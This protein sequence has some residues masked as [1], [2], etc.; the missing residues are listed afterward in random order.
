MKDPGAHVTKT[1]KKS[2]FRETL[3]YEEITFTIKENRHFF[4][5]KI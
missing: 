2:F 5:A 1:E 4:S 3:I